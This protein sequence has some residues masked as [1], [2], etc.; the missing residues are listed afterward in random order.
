M[1]TQNKAAIESTHLTLKQAEDLSLYRRLLLIT[2]VLYPIFG[3]I[4]TFVHEPADETI[5][6]FFQRI[7]FSL[8]I[9]IS[10]FFSYY[11]KRVQQR[12][13]SVISFFVYL[14]FSHLTYI[15]LIS[16]YSMNHLVGIVMVYV[17]TSLVFRKNLD[18]NIY[19]VYATCISIITAF[20]AP[21]GDISPVMVILIISCIS[22]VLFVGIN[23]KIKA[24]IRLKH[25]EA[26]FT[27]ITENTSDLIWSI[28]LN[29]KLLSA[30]QAALDH[31]QLQG[32]HSI[33]VGKKIDLLIITSTLKEEWETY[34]QRALSGE[35]FTII[36]EEETNAQVYEHSFYPIKNNKKIVRGTCVFSRNITQQIDRENKLKFAQR[37]AKTGSFSRNYI[38]GTYTWSDY[39]YEL[40]QLPTSTDIH[41]LEM[42]E[43]IHPEDYSTYESMF[44]SAFET[45]KSFSLQ[46]RIVRKNFSIIPVLANIVMLLNEQKKV[47][48]INGTIQDYS[49]QSRLQL[50]E[51][52]NQSLQK[53]KEFSEILNQQFTTVLT[54]L[55]TE[56]QTPLDK[57]LGISKLFSSIEIS[58]PTKIEYVTEIQKSSNQLLSILNK[59]MNFNDLSKDSITLSIENYSIKELFNSIISKSNEASVK[60]NISLRYFIEKE[61][62]DLQ[63]GDVTHLTRVLTQLLTTS[64][65]MTEQGEVMLAAATEI[66]GSDSYLLFKIIDTGQGYTEEQQRVLFETLDLNEDQIEFKNK[67]SGF[68]LPICNKLVE[69]MGGTLQVS[70]WVG[71][72][73]EFVIRFPL[74]RSLAIKESQDTHDENAVLRILLVEDNTFNQMVAI[75]TIEGW[76]PKV[77]IQIAENGEEA[78]TALQKSTYNLILMDIQMPVMD[79]HEASKI[80]RKELDEPACSTP[81]I[82]VTAHAFTEEITRCY[83]NGMNDYISKPFDGDELIEK[84]KKY[85]RNTIFH[86]E[87][88][89][90]KS[91]LRTI[92]NF[93]AIEEFTNG[94]K[95]RIHK[96]VSMFLKDTPNELS[97]LK[98]L[99]DEVNYA[100]IQT[101]AH[102]F[103]PKYMYMGMVE[104][105]ETAKK[106]EYLAKEEGALEE[107]QELFAYLEG[108][109]ELAY[110]VLEQYATP[111]ES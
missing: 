80:I 8:L 94:K 23:M 101:L 32:M 105:S 28:D 72:G 76:N 15:A 99:I 111:M 71:L 86:S 1:N 63:N 31:F 69:L 100:A 16:G 57:L 4:N 60:K 87:K 47:V 5:A 3:Y 46:Y 21:K 22:M 59:V 14:G 53:E 109:S 78:I 106:I 67:T 95:E 39:M 104:L 51:K 27:A 83:E 110:V 24:E 70:S 41:A 50:L 108:Q 7:I 96:M 19:I 73:S 88:S 66:K 84:I 17:G 56:I 89:E 35:I 91:N 42:K 20:M 61:I 43:F 44:T 45:G 74:S 58:N 13:Y 81:I 18:L 10:I 79:G 9:S 37:I 85:A 11:S 90:E 26:N 102:S 40:F 48:E 107:I 103:K 25:N 49:E 93:K 82:A 65:S 33:A 36:Q 68:E 97:R 6:I 77:Q 12:F 98:S 55:Q 38:T 54:N 75:E 92:V 29:Y 30:N 64:I 2:V 62:D 52:N 34:Y